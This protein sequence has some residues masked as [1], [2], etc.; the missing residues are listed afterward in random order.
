MDKLHEAWNGKFGP[1]VK[2]PEW[3]SNF[4]VQDVCEQDVERKIAES[5]VRIG[6][7]REEIEKELFLLTWLKGVRECGPVTA[8]SL[9]LSETTES[10]EE[11]HV[12]GDTDQVFEEKE[13]LNHP[14]E[15]PRLSVITGKSP[16]GTPD[17]VC[18]KSL[19][20]SCEDSPSSSEYHTAGQGSSSEEVSQT[21]LAEEA[22]P[23]T[24]ARDVRERSIDRV[25]FKDSLVA[26]GVRQRLTEDRLHRSCE[27][28]SE[29]NKGD[30]SPSHARKHRRNSSAPT[31][32][33]DAPPQGNQTSKEDPVSRDPCS[34]S[35]AT[36]V[37]SK[38]TEPS[39]LTNGTDTTF[40]VV[41]R[42]KVSRRPSLPMS[43]E[44]AMNR[45]KGTGGVSSE[46]ADR[47]SNGMLDS[48]E[49]YAFMV[50]NDEDSDPALINVM[51]SRM[52]GAHR[53]S[54]SSVSTDDSPT[55]LGRTSDLVSPV[56]D[57]SHTPVPGAEAAGVSAKHT[58]P[59][60][61]RSGTYDTSPIKR[62]RFS[63]HYSDD[64]C[65]TPKLDSGDHS[66]FSNSPNSSNRCSHRNSRSSNGIID[67]E[68]AYD[69][70]LRKDKSD[71]PY[72][73][74][75][76]KTITP[77]SPA[78]SRALA[79]SGDVVDDRQLT[80]TLTP[81]IGYAAVSHNELDERVDSFSELEGL[82]LGDLDIDVDLTLSKLRNK[83]EMSMAT[84]LD[85]N[86]NIEMNA[87]L[88]S[89]EFSLSE[90]LEY[91][92]DEATI[93][94]VTV[95]NEMYGSRSNSANSIPGLFSEQSGMSPPEQES[96][97]HSAHQGVNLRQSGG[98]KRSHRKRMGNLDLEMMTGGQSSDNDNLSRSSASLTSE[99][100]ST[101]PGMMDD[102]L[103]SNV[104]LLGRRLEWV[105]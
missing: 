51:A 38:Q 9:G 41:L 31:F 87:Q 17:R 43:C 93:S 68:G 55:S 34:D 67:E 27:V 26:K 57:P 18:G 104:S 94:A 78:E 77:D 100:E 80:S 84:L 98:V 10:E 96:P 5:E 33:L 81:H 15:V 36:G 71:V 62:D 103:V 52:R 32:V 44:E 42:E 28:L 85:M 66:T 65:L 60:R 56:E 76:K 86:E 88:P 101:S 24:L 74:E 30:Y 35:D 99:E 90:D 19:A 13:A 72:K 53:T 73:L 45:W 37:G 48:C 16:V 2:L 95:S 64:E 97:T 82:K 25:T 7:L 83:P 3:V 61:K 39:P 92:I 58:A 63:Y 12:L 79:L 59:L 1:E 29:S 105:Y 50:N 6:K 70:T 14:I 4:S 21:N 54:R 46:R 75:R 102:N 47:S 23:T 11:N 91:G 8:P 49:G 89:R 40:R 20:T 69:L 22:T